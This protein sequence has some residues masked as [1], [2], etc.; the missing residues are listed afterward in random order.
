MNSV[1][2]D[3]RYAI[4]S[5][6]RR[7]GF[8]ALAVLTLAIGIGV[9]TVAFSAI[10][11]LLLR[12]FH[13][14]GADRVG[15]I[16]LESPGNPHGNASLDD[17]EL[18]SRAAAG[19]AGIAAEGRL[20]VSL[21]TPAGAEQAWTMAVSANYLDIVRARA[22]I[23]RLFTKQDVEGSEIPVV[24]SHRFWRDKLDGGASVAGRTIVLNGRSCAIVGV[25]PDDFQGPGGLYAPDVWLPLERLD[26]LNTA[27]SL[28]SQSWLTLFGRLRD[29]VT[30]AQVNAE[31][32]SVALSLPAAARHDKPPTVR[33]FPMKDGHPDLQGI[34]RLAWVAMSIV[35]LILLIACFNVAAL[36]MARAHERQREIGVR[37][38]LGASRGRILRQL[39]TEGMVLAAVSGIATLIVATW[40]ADLLST[41]SLPSPIPQR[42]HLGI[43]R[44]LVG[45]TALL[46]LIAGMLPAVVP[47][48]QATS[49]NLQRS[50]RMESALGASPSRA[51]NAFVVL[52]VAGSTLFVAAA[53]LFVRS[54]LNTA[55]LDPG[56]NTTQ[57]VVMQLSPSLYGYDDERARH[58]IEA[59]RTKI[60]SVNGVAAA[61]IADRVP[62]YVGYPRTAEYTTDAADCAATDCRRATVYA[63]GPGHFDAL[64]IALRQGG[65]FPATAGAEIVISEKMASQLWPGQSAVGKTLRIGDDGR[66]VQVIGVAADIKHRNM[67]E[68]PGAYLYR[69]LAKGEWAEALTII[70]R[71]N[72]D[73][74]LLLSAIQEQVRATDPNLPVAVATMSERMKMPLWPVRTAAGFF[75]ICGSL[76]LVLATVGLFGV[77]YFT[78]MQRTREFG[79]RIAIGASPRRVVSVVLREGLTLAVPGVLLGGAAALA[80]ARLL[81]RGLFGVS[82]ADPLSFSATALIQ[83]AVT[84]AACALPAYRA[85]RVDPMVALRQD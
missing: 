71:A 66:P 3:L 34:S 58:M 56:F 39:V 51:R 18:L 67:S 12:P 75:A 48:V 55:T 79:I 37:S 61:A 8:A 32:K 81:S 64:G 50:L 38:A 33:F 62:F 27:A 46:V 9:N 57:T 82:P 31:L 35:G 84:I 43:D 6:V 25:L 5:L 14:A 53:L 15:W 85:T 26:A 78:V 22:E 72:G 11:A 83:I 49:S 73:P 65:D 76:A 17:F 40:S 59:L 7:P 47:A 41:F 52:Q 54:F 70:V 4:R 24:V 23:G 74:R 42:M 29:G 60:A 80:G 21:R 20:P 16:L 13:T 36:L 19:F 69:P 68:A 2:Q 30:R 63:V 28:R 77:L 45:F 44:T 1:S 10:N